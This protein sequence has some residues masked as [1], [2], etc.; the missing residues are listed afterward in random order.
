MIID[1]DQ[2]I[3]KIAAAR[4]L[5]IRKKALSGMKPKYKLKAVM[6]INFNADV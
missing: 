1:D 2:E 3:R 5:D 4:I 6:P